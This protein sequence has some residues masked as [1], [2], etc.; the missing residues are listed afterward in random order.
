MRTVGK[1]RFASTITIEKCEACDFSPIPVKAIAMFEQAIAA[2]IALFGPVNGETFRCLRISLDL[3]V[4]EVARIANVT[5]AKV[6]RWERES[7][8]VDTGAWLVLA[9]LVR[10]R[11]A[12]ALQSLDVESRQ[13]RVA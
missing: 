3:D 11:T 4:E 5:L 12:R 10:E 9:D 2:R 7:A 6:I 13:A 8:H 1:R